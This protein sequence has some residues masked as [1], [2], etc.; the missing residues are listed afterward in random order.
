MPVAGALGAFVGEYT[1]QEGHV[2][3]CTAWKSTVDSNK[4]WLARGRNG[5]WMGQ[6]TDVRRHSRALSR[7]PVAAGWAS[8][9]DVPPSA[10]ALCP[11]S[12]LV[13]SLPLT[14]G[15]RRHLPLA[16]SVAGC[17]LRGWAVAWA[18]GL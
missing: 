10:C 17:S 2:N 4:V 13:A 11:S 6:H 9:R 12:P 16:T 7:R 3:G 15:P 1:L 5:C 14:V 8:T 18:A